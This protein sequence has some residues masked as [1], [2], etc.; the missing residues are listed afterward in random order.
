MLDALATVEASATEGG[1]E[2][3]AAMMRKGVL[4]VRERHEAFGIRTYPARCAEQTAWKALHAAIAR[5]E[6]WLSPEE[7][8]AH[9]TC[10][11][12]NFLLFWFSV[13]GFYDD[14]IC[15]HDAPKNL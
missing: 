10:T 13:L 8:Q 12:W 14:K 2:A 1:N 4:A 9:Q 3:G 5:E 7:L 15:L 11:S 6:Y